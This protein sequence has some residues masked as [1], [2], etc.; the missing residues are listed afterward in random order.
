MIQPALIARLFF[1]FSSILTTLSAVSASAQTGAPLSTI[2]ARSTPGLCKAGYLWRRANEADQVC[3]T[4]A[5]RAKVAAENAVRGLQKADGTCLAGYVLREANATDHVC[6][7]PGERTETAAQNAVA[8]GHALAATAGHSETGNPFGAVHVRPSPPPPP[9]VIGCYRYRT[10]GENLEPARWVKVACLS[11][12]ELLKVPHP[13]LGGNAGAPGIQS[14]PT[15][16]TFGGSETSGLAGGSVTV[17]LTG[18]SGSMNDSQFGTYAFS[19]QLNTNL[20]SATC[21]S[22]V[23]AALSA[24]L[25]AV[26]G[27]NCIPGDNAAVQF[28]YQTWNKTKTSVI[29]VWNVDVTQQWY[30]FPQTWQEC[31]NVA[32]P[33]FWIANQPLN[34]SGNVN[35]QNH[36]LTTIVALPWTTEWDSVVAPDWLGLCWA[37]GQ[38]GPQCA[39]NQTSGT[40]LGAGN[41]SQ[42]NFSSNSFVQTIVGASAA[43]VSNGCKP[44]VVPFISIANPYNGA[45]ANGQGT[46]E[47]NNLSTYYFGGLPPAVCSGIA[48]TLTYIASASQP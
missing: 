41:G 33:G 2:A 11:R 27:Q 28:T 37:P 22:S 5:E 39:W 7:T 15:A 14:Q 35:F 9:A 36:L 16:L 25:A 47:S 19:V 1:L 29:C 12:A 45:E 10:E 24:L 42:V 8:S 34:V 32:R 23:Y 40:I 13:T 44:G 30:T 18:G 48:C 31:Q 3:V 26:G 46:V 4:R 20:F 6:V 21:H 17:S 38:L 43:C